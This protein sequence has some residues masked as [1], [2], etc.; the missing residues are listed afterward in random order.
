MLKFGDTYLKYGDTYLTDYNG[1]IEPYPFEEVRIG[2][3]VWAKYNLSGN[4]GNYIK[5][6]NF[7]NIDYRFSGTQY[8]YWKEPEINFPGWRIPTQEDFEIL[9]NTI[10]NDAKKIRSSYGWLGN[11]G[12]QRNR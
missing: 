9:K 12:N 6:D 4:Y 3:Q 8:F 2:P 1:K 11:S 5:V 10:G 7:S